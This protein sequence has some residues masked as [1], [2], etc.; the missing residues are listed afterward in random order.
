[1]AMNA[2]KIIE[3]IEA[4]DNAERI[5]TL[6]KLFDK[7]FDSR[8]PKEVIEEEKFKSSWGEDSEQ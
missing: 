8:P 5:R 7:Y 6:E 1:M 2:E 3:Q 4:M